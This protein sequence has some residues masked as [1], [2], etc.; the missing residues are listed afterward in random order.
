VP[1]HVRVT[2]TGD[3]RQAGLARLK[4]KLGAFAY[5]NSRHGIDSTPSLARAGAAILCEAAIEYTAALTGSKITVDPSVQVD[6]ERLRLAAIAYVNSRHGIDG[7]VGLTR[8]GL[9][10]LCAAAIEYTEA[11]TGADPRKRPVDP[12]LPLENGDLR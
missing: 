7:E 4:L 1:T 3:S 8:A 2:N 12:T 11:L 6:D 5:T 10:L 9:A